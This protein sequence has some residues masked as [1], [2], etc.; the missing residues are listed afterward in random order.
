[1]SFFYL[2]V[3]RRYAIV[4]SVV[5]YLMR[6]PDGGFLRC[7]AC[8]FFCTFVEMKGGQPPE[9]YFTQN[10]LKLNLNP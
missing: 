4:Y 9:Y 5:E 10:I 7:C 3:E 6:R 8:V 2:G 1:M